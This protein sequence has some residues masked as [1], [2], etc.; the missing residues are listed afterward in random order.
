AMLSYDHGDHNHD[1]LAPGLTVTQAHYETHWINGAQVTL[2]ADPAYS[3]T[4]SEPAPALAAVETTALQPLTSIPLLHSDPSATVKLYLDFDGHFE[5]EWGG[6]TNVTTPIY[7]RD[8]DS[9]TFSDAEINFIIMAWQKTSEDFAPFNIDV[10][11]EEPPELAPGVPESVANGVALRVSIGGDGSWTGGTYG[12]IAQYDSFTNSAPNVV[13]VFPAGTGDGR[14]EGDVSSHEAGHAFGLQHQSLYDAQGNLINSYHPGDGNWAPIMGYLYV[15]VTTWHNGTSSSATT[16][17]DD[18]AMI[19]RAQN[20]FGYRADDH[21]NTLATASPISFDGTNVTVSGFIGQ[22]AD[23]DYWSFT[24]AAQDT[25]RFKVDPAVIG[26]NLDAVLELRDVA[27]AL[28]AS[29]SPTAIQAAELLLPL[30]PATYFISVAKTA[31]YGWLGQYSLEISAPAAAVLA[32]AIEPVIVPE[33]SAATVTFILQTQPTA[34]VTI[35]LAVSDPS[36]ATISAASLTF[37]PANWNVPQAVTISGID[38]GV[39][40]DDIAFSVLVGTVTSLDAEYNGLDPS[41]VAAVSTDHGY[42]G[43][44]YWTDRSS[45]LIQRSGLGGGPV[46][47]LVDLK[48]LYGGSPDQ[49]NPRGMAID[50]AGGKMYWV[51]HNAGRIQRANLDGSNVEI[52]LSGFGNGTLVGIE[53]D[54]A[55]GKMYWTNYSA[56]QIQRANVDGTGLENL[57]T[58][59]NGIWDVTLD[60]SAGKMYWSTWYGGVVVIHRANTDGSGAELLWTG[61]AASS[62]SGLALDTPASKMY[63]YDAVTRQILRSNLD[64]SDVQSAA[65]LS[66]IPLSRVHWINVD[67]TAGKLYWSDL[68]NGALYRSNLDGSNIVRLVSGLAQ[69]Q[70]MVIVEPAVSVTPHSGLLTSESGATA[71]FQVALTTPPAT[72]VTIPI[73]SGDATEGSVS[74]ASLTFTPADWNV[75]QS[76]IVTGVNDTIF[77]GDVA[78]S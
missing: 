65:D 55:A 17:Q 27:G 62:P 32:G 38:D 21:A 61:A 3:G 69:P 26:P 77:D 40:D 75:P 10:T 30:A 60:T 36:Q 67:P 42:G 43:Y 53:L 63:W 14:Y 13:Y 4:A 58:G 73:S 7:D 70:Q 12:G 5:A 28:I 8:G 59:Q 48:A 33:R 71:S 24:V 76:V 20:G 16:F 49:Y 11:T 39:V 41:D 45:D 18:M 56:G 64:G 51:D 68:G 15:P 29:A 66:S 6:R 44:A 37:T 47:T 2:V 25:Y 57:V 31:A 1:H 34:D 54:L 19:A 22:N 78:Y 46:E 23:I 35:P 52:I 50:M 9:T 72:D 74:A